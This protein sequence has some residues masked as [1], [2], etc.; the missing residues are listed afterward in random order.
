MNKN[1]ILLN[2]Y[3]DTIIFSN[4]LDLS[5]S[6]LSISNLFKYSNKFML[7]SISF[8]N[9]FKILKCSASTS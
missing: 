9:V 7:T 5:V 2:M 3:Y 6:I 1:K 8:I 4:Q